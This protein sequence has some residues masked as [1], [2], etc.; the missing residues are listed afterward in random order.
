LTHSHRPV[1]KNSMPVE[2]LAECEREEIRAGIERAESDTVIAWRL[3][4]D[5]SMAM[6]KSPLVAR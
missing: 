5:L 6:K 4:R 2:P 1:E 3:G